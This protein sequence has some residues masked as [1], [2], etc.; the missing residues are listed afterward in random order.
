MFSLNKPIIFDR[1]FYIWTGWKNG[2]Y[3]LRNPLSPLEN[4]SPWGNQTHDCFVI[5]GLTRN[6]AFSALRYWMPDQVRHDE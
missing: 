2:L 5:P 6:P 1:L 3:T 4:V